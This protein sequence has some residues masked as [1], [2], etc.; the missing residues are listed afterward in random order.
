MICYTEWL[1]VECRG[2]Q[3]LLALR[4]NLKRMTVKNGIAYFTMTYIEQC[5]LDTNA[6]KQQSYAATDV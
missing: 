6:G 3:M 2:A 4:N 1:S 5:I